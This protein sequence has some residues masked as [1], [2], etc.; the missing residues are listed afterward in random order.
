M[1]SDRAPAL[2]RPL[3]GP[4]SAARLRHLQHRFR[5]AGARPELPTLA[6]LALSLAT[7]LLVLFGGFWVLG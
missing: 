2:N 1:S 7:F 3:E 4:G 6:V 5:Q